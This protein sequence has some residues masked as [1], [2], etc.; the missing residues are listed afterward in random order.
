MLPFL[1]FRHSGGSVSPGLLRIFLPY[2]AFGL[3]FTTYPVPGMVERLGPVRVVHVLVGHAVA[4]FARMPRRVDSGCGA[5]V[6]VYIVPL[7]LLAR[8]GGRRAELP[9]FPVAWSVRA[10]LLRPLF[11]AVNKRWDTQ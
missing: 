8:G 11:M 9:P 10:I 7:R 4:V 1:V 5:V 6:R 3:S 2:L